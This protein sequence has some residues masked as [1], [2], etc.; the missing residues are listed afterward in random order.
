MQALFSR[1]WVT[2][3]EKGEAGILAAKHGES[4][5]IQIFLHSLIQEE[6]GQDAFPKSH[7]S[8]GTTPLCQGP[9]CLKTLGLKSCQRWERFGS[10]AE[11]EEKPPPFEL[12][13]R[14]VNCLL[15]YPVPPQLKWEPTSPKPDSIVRVVPVCVPLI[16][17]TCGPSLLWETPC[18]QGG[19]MDLWT[20]VQT[21]KRSHYFYPTKLN[22]LI[23]QPAV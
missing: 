19:P 23:T 8:L 6:R 5:S 1:P 21:P 10:M 12:G 14:W 2:L 15:K 7:P 3:G 16:H 17:L 9:R 20:S 4:I 11:A 18:F 22:L 13:Y